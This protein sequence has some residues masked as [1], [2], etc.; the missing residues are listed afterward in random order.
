MKSQVIRVA[1]QHKQWT[2]VTWL[3]D[4]RLSE[5]LLVSVRVNGGDLKKQKAVRNCISHHHSSIETIIRLN[6]LSTQ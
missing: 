6:H 3:T 1:M 2:L 5:Q 4:D